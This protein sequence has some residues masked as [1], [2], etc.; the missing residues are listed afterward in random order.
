MDKP[1]NRASP[2]PKAIPLA[3]AGSTAPMITR[4]QTGSRVSIFEEYKKVDVNN[5]NKNK[6][7]RRL[8]AAEFF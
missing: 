1:R 6:V 2:S 4:K 5:N 7:V 3:S 8:S